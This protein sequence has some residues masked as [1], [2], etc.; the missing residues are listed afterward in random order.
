MRLPRS[1]VLLDE[2]S[3]DRRPDYLAW[4]D[5]HSVE[6]EEAR[7]QS[8]KPQCPIVVLWVQRV[9]SRCHPCKQIDGVSVSRGIRLTFV[10]KT[11]VNCIKLLQFMVIL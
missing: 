8:R 3:G 10:Y 4:G 11:Y 7:D 2:G 9:P 6:L 5:R 1:A